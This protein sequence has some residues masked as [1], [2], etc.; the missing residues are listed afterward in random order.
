MQTI[1]L[2]C[3]ARQT[4]IHV[5]T[6]RDESEQRLPVQSQKFNVIN[7]IFPAAS[8]S[9]VL[10]LDVTQSGFLGHSETAHQPEVYC[11]L[12]PQVV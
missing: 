8:E 6:R 4:D 1:C 12:S 7:C 2:R 9:S 11:R 3:G 10:L 5:E